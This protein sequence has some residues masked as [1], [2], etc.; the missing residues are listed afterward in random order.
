MLLVGSF[1]PASP[2][3]IISQYHS[4][5]VERRW[6]VVLSLY[7]DVRVQLADGSGVLLE[8]FA[9]ASGDTEQRTHL[10]HRWTSPLWKNKGQCSDDSKTS[11]HSCC[12]DREEQTGHV[13]VQQEPVLPLEPWSTGRTGQRPGPGYRPAG[14]RKELRHCAVKLLRYLF[15]GLWEHFISIKTNEPNL[16]GTLFPSDMN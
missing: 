13:S 7:A 12:W 6:R 16:N 14:R 3:V 10:S 5:P 8:H 2:P 11:C 15:F 1:Q 9:V 4:S